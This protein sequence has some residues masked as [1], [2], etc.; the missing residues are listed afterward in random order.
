MI[1][2]SHSRKNSCKEGFDGLGNSV[3]LIEEES[4]YRGESW[5]DHSSHV[6]CSQLY[7]WWGLGEGTLGSR[8]EVLCCEGCVAVDLEEAVGELPESIGSIL[9]RAIDVGAVD[10]G[11]QAIELL[12]GFR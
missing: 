6:S 7:C 9:V 5:L 1:M 12:A 8:G 2:R 3:V 4:V 10:I 11:G